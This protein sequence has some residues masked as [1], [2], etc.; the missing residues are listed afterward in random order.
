MADRRAKEAFGR[1]DNKRLPVIP[2]ELPA[3]EVE[4]LSRSRR[5]G[6][7][8]VHCWRTLV[9]VRARFAE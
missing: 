7:M 2:F 4:V 8:Y 3:Q 1:R 9:R 5:I 6:D